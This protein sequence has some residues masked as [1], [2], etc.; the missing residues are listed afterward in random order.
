M[1]NNFE[2]QLIEL[3]KIVGKSKTAFC[4]GTFDGVH[5]GHV[6]L[7]K[8]L[9]S[10]SKKSNLKSLS[11][12]FK[13]R[14]REIINENYF[15]PYLSTL[16]HRINKINNLGLDF[17]FPLEFNQELKKLSA[18]NFLQKL[19]KFAN[20]KSMIVSLNTKI[21]TDQMSGDKLKSLCKKLDIDVF[22]INMKNIDKDIISSS[23]ISDLL[24]Q[25]KI[26]NVNNYL[27]E[28]YTLSG[29]VEKGDQIGRTIGFPTANIKLQEKIQLPS[30]GI[31][32]CYVKLGDKLLLG[33]LSIGN[34]PTIKNDSSHK[35]EVFIID[36][37][38]NIYDEII[39]L[40]IVDKV[41]AQVEFRSL[42]DLKNQMKK[43]I[44]KIKK[45]LNK[46]NE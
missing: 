35:I 36:F 21:G 20:I 8:N 19:S 42:D 33:A 5:K 7:F 40:L 34:R 44:I 26:I 18:E 41:R 24:I 6:S 28:K 25:G 11:L 3:S 1:K 38:E 31:Y 45:I 17:V 23:K 13:K 16:N 10:L 15:R 12:V 4:I 32:A 14:P 30:D 37:K 2:Q 43:D 29:K 9:I 27:G 22:F 39:E 46:E